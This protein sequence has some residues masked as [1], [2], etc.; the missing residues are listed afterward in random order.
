[1]SEKDKQDRRMAK[2][3]DKAKKKKLPIPLHIALAVIHGACL[4]CGCAIH[5]CECK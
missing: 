5:E 4:R 3:M 2:E 1:M